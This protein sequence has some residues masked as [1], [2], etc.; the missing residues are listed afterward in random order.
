MS[1]NEDAGRWTTIWTG[2]RRGVR[3]DRGA[4]AAYGRAF[5]WE[6]SARQFR[7]ALTPLRPVPLAASG[8][9]VAGDQHQAYHERAGQQGYR[10]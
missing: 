5:S 8:D 3:R 2:D 4:C 7:A 6:A 10:A 9:P 1:L